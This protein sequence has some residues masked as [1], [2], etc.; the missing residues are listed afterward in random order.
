MILRRVTFD[1]PIAFPDG[2]FTNEIRNG[3]GGCRLEL[4]EILGVVRVTSPGGV[5]TWV[6]TSRCVMERML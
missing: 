4:D 2:T 5:E 3:I 1:R 6:S